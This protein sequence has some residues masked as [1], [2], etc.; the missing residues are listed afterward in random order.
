MVSVQGG[1]FYSEMYPCPIFFFKL[2]LLNLWYVTQIF[3]SLWFV[4]NL[5]SSTRV[6]LLRKAKNNLKIALGCAGVR[7]SSRRLSENCSKAFLYFVNLY[8]AIL[9]SLHSV[10]KKTHFI[11]LLSC[12][13]YLKQQW[14]SGSKG[15]FTP[16]QK[17]EH[18][19]L[20]HSF[21]GTATRNQWMVSQESQNF[22]TRM[23]YLKAH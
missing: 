16:P 19:G 10:R 17:Y 21:T 15:S 7:R 2:R 11:K 6:F 1:L 8:S 13:W 14:L 9:F 12:K 5:Y 18:D 22:E 3:Y 4:L 23:L 20:R